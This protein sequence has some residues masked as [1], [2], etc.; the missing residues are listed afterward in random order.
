MSRHWSSDPYFTDA[1]DRYT[2][3]RDSD[4][5][6]IELDISLIESI[7]FN[8]DGPAYRL[9]EAMNNLQ[10]TEGDEGHR[11]APRILLAVLQHLKELSEK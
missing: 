2:T 3:A 10:E 6:T 9:M 7:I 8:G 1:L 4:Q 5:K 11:G